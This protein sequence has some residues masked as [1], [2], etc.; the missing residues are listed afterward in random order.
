MESKSEI[1]H[2]VVAIHQPNFA[3]YS[4]FF[5]KM[6]S[7][8]VFVYLD[9]APYSK[10]SFQNRNRIL[11]KDGIQWLTVP[12]LTKGNY[13]SPTNEIMINNQIPWKK[14]H[15]GNLQQNYSDAPFFKEI[16]A[17]IM[18][19]YEESCASLVEFCS[20]ILMSI[21]EYLGITTATCNA[22]D[23]SSQGTSTQRLIELIRNVGG[24]SYISGQG[25]RNYIDETLFKEN[26]IAL[27]YQDYTMRSYSQRADIF[28]PNLSILDTLYWCGRDAAIGII[29]GGN[30]Q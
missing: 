19:V 27:I 29:K 21:R 16:Y 6:A 13:G 2:P 28:V 23:L 30:E 8:D 12:V 24:K 5:N 14:K 11:T 15:L 1:M 3:P 7:A 18:S 25:G 9:D 10:N 26:E 20:R 22:S 4:G 17:M